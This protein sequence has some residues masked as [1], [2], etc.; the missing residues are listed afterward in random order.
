MNILASLVT[1]AAADALML[2]GLFGGGSLYY[3]LACAAVAAAAILL[4]ED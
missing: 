3:F 2:C 1:L 4:R